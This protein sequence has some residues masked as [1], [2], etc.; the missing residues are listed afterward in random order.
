MSLGSVANARVHQVHLVGEP[1]G[2]LVTQSHLGRRDPVQLRQDPHGVEV[3]GPHLARRGPLGVIAQHWLHALARDQ[4]HRHERRNLRQVARI[5]EEHV[6]RQ[7]P[8]TLRDVAAEAEEEQRRSPRM[9][10]EWN[11]EVDDQGQHYGN[12]ASSSGAV[13][14]LTGANLQ[15]QDAL[16]IAQNGGLTGAEM[17]R[18]QTQKET[19][20]WMMI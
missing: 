11:N 4:V 9:S 18:W 15:Q 13:N 14:S 20:A 1:D 12:N 17:P 5:G 10:T 2:G 3:P 19:M 8:Q 6:W 7:R 16:A